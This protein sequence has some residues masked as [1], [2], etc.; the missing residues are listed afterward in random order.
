MND[1][2]VTYNVGGK[3]TYTY[4][5]MDKL[6]FDAAG[7]PLAIKWP[8]IWLFGILA[9]LPKIKKAGKHDSILFSK[10]TLSHG[11]VGDTVVG[12]KSF[13]EYIKAYFGKEN[14]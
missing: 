10:W 12:S 14:N 6:C 9:N 1:T 2:N 3:E 5:E 13:G 4:E 7:K 11:L 8:P